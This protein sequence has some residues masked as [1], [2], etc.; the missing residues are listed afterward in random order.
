MLVRVSFRRGKHPFCRHFSCRRRDSNPRHADYDSAARDSSIRKSPGNQPLYGPQEYVRRRD[1]GAVSGP[2]WGQLRQ[3]TT[4]SAAGGST[5]RPAAV[6]RQ[7]R[8]HLA[9]AS[10]S[11]AAH[12]HNLARARQ[13]AR[14]ISGLSD[15]Q[16]ARHR[17][18]ACAR[19]AARAAD[20]A[21]S[22][23]TRRARI[24]CTRPSTRT[25]AACEIWSRAGAGRRG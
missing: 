8:V 15:D 13:Q 6:G 7:R 2:F 24:S 22:R 21:R 11:P 20:R 25:W 12:R 4:R 1:F 19:S 18:C 3:F 5:R 9:K 16:D 23:A 10:R 14:T 17:S